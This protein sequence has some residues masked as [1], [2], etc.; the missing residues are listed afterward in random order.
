[1][2]S[3]IIPSG[4][5]LNLMASFLAKQLGKLIRWSLMGVKK[6]GLENPFWAAD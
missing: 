4:S 1:M 2:P 5:V 6:G 3:V